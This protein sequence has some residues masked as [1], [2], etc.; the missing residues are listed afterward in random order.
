MVDLKGM[1]KKAKIEYI[2][3]YYKIHIIVTTL[4][5][6]GLVSFIHGQIT[7]INYEFNLTECRKVLKPLKL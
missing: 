4:V 7:K 2:W 6:I 5:L 3:D 1:T